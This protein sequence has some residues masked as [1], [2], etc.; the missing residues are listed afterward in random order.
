MYRMQPRPDAAGA[1]DL[2][3]RGNVGANDPALS[4]RQQPFTGHGGVVRSVDALCLAVR[5]K[6]H[7]C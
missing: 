3:Y 6:C 7:A 4:A 2:T 1:E 5:D